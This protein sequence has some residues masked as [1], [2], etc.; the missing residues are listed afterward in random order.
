MWEI[1]FLGDPAR[2]EEKTSSATNRNDSQFS[3]L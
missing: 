1:S 3:E 2:V